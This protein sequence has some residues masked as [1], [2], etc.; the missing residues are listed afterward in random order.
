MKKIINYL[1]N[2]DEI[3][4]VEYNNIFVSNLVWINREVANDIATF[5][6]VVR[7][8][9]KFW[10]YYVFNGLDRFVELLLNFKFN[11]EAVSILKKIGLTDS[12]NSKTFYKNFKFSGDVWA[13]SD[14][15]IFYPGEPIVRITAPLA[16]ANSL[17]AFVLNAFC[18]PIRI[19]TKSLRIKIAGGNTLYFGGPLVRLPGFE[20]AIFTQQAAFLLDSPIA[21]PFFYKKFKQYK[22]SGKIV[23]N[24]NHAIIKSFT[25]EREAYRYVLDELLDKAN[26]FYVM[27]D[28]YDLKKGLDI[29]IEEIKKTKPFDR[30][31]IMITIDSGD[32]KKQ[33][34]YVRKT[35]NKNNLNKIRIQAMSNLDEYS[36]DQMVKEKTP[37]DCFISA[38]SVANITD[39]PKLEVVYK[40]TELKRLNGKI[41]YKVKLAEGKISYPG[42]K[43]IF[44]KYKNKKM[45]KDIIGLE[46]ENLGTELLHKIIE[47]GKLKTKMP[48]LEEI[49]KHFKNEI[50]SL[51]DEYKKIKCL[52]VYPVEKSKKLI[53]LFEKSKKLHTTL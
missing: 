50:K 22:P 1:I 39:N 33:A 6:L 12:N 10:G 52:N 7:E 51:P 30:C 16:E 2:L 37:I 36:I 15:T 53:S 38:T 25:E 41:E 4:L 45:I 32:L 9:P 42:K 21:S 49:K 20:Q 47:S 35:L 44:R 34:H 27:I 46:N 5:D 26:F 3:P 13:L 40:L 48:T 23:A 29:F 43:Q 18:Y 24:I 19:I 31:K 11:K 14:G 17:T 8:L 28:T